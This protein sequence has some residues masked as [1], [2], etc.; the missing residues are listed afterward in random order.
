M[1][2]GLVSVKDFY[3]HNSVADPERNFI[4]GNSGKFKL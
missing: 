2:M 1:F 3:T 4:V